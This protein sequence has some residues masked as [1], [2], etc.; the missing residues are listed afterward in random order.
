MHKSKKS[1]KV[2][3][4]NAKLRVKLNGSKN[5]ARSGV[6]VRVIVQF[7]RGGSDFKGKRKNERGPFF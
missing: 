5:R 6:S 1:K 3:N 7:R 4:G 2:K